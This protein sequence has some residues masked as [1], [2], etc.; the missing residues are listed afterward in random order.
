MTVMP[1]VAF[2]LGAGA[3]FPYGIPMMTEMYSGFVEYVRTKRPQC[4]PLLRQIEAG[5]PMQDIESLISNLDKIRSIREGMKVLGK[6]DGELSPQYGSS[7]R[8]SRILG[9][10]FG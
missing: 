2:L 1:R 6:I 3:S 4:E 7:R 8:A 5:I 9:L 10:V